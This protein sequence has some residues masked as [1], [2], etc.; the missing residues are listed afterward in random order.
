VDGNAFEGTWDD[1]LGYTIPEDSTDFDDLVDV[2]NIGIQGLRQSG[3]ISSVVDTAFGADLPLLEETVGDMTA[4]SQK[5]VT[6]FLRDIG[7]GGG[8]VQR[9]RAMM[10][11]TG[12]LQDS[13]MNWWP[14]DSRSSI[15]A[16]HRMALAT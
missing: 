14:L 2:F 8:G 4:A 13:R 7:T 12:T 9:A 6:P 15:W 16:S 5:F 1:L 3:N 11:T 10:G